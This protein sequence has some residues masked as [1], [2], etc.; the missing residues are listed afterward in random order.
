MPS[1]PATEVVVFADGAPQPAF[2]CLRVERATGGGMKDSATIEIDLS[3]TGTG[4]GYIQNLAIGSL[5]G[6]LIEVWGY[7]AGVPT[8]WHRGTAVAP[9]LE[10]GAHGERLTFTS[11]VEP[12]HFG[13]VMDGVL[14]FD[15]LTG[16]VLTLPDECVF[17]PEIDDA[18]FANQ[19]G[20]MQLFGVAPVMLDPE[21]C[22]TA[23]ALTVQGDAPL[24]WTP[25]TAVAYLCWA[26]NGQ[27]TYLRNPTGY[28]LLPSWPLQNFRLERGKFLCDY[29]DEM[30]P[31]WGMTW[32]LDYSSG[33]PTIA[34]VVRGL[35]TPNSVYL[36][37][38]GAAYSGDNA[39]HSTVN[40]DVG[41]ARNQAVVYGD[42]HFVESTWSLQ[43]GWP[44]A[45]DATP[46][47]SLTKD[48]TDFNDPSK[49]YRDVWRKWVLNEAGDY[50]GTR[51]E[52]TA[53][54]DLAA[55]V[56][57][58]VTPRRR[59]FLPS[60]TLGNDLSPFGEVGG[61]LVEYSVDGAVTW[62]PIAKLED[63]TCVLL[64]R[65]CGIRFDGLFP[66]AE[67][68]RAG[69][70]PGTSLQ[71]QVRITATIR[72]DVRLG[73]IVG[74]DAA[75]PLAATAPFLIDEQEKFHW[76]EVLPT[77]KNY[78]AVQSGEL[79]A[80]QANDLAALTD[81][82]TWLQEVFDVAD[83]GG[84]LVVEGLD[85]GVYQLGDLITTINGRNISL[86]AQ[87]AASG[88]VRAP[89]VVGISYDAQNQRRTLILETMRDR[90]AGDWSFTTPKDRA[91]ATHGRQ[92]HRRRRRA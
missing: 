21:S 65:E 64:E 37:P 50:V 4:A 30:L 86:N 92:P 25:Q 23:E 38:P 39:L 73:A 26:L 29:L 75:S 18:I 57:H 10:I 15:P 85:N 59:K 6:A 55:L 24:L 12:W 83:A 17:N 60:I 2:R 62:H 80:D 58:A 61:A 90:V 81:Y 14:T 31:R 44:E 91:R 36:G 3:S 78:P 46:E 51:P 28:G 56:G 34:F 69:S 66:P 88:Q 68:M 7:P 48:S 82:A 13:L 77:S 70:Q 54:Y 11:R 22:R 33:Q 47:T 8:L 49:N 76:R 87:S 1:R 71:A 20:L 52:I 19:S 53:P 9:S 42:W 67:L 32:G 16:G 89:Q 41:N 74:P 40:Y 5:A 72:D 43:K 84:H 35:G 63:R 45:L 79:T 27:Q